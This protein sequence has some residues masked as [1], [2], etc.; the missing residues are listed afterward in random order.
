MVLLHPACAFD[1][2]STLGYVLVLYFIKG[3]HVCYML[4]VKGM[5]LTSAF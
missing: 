2:T 3:I 4:S 1:V 5:C